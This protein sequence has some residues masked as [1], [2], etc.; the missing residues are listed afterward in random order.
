[1]AYQ[2][3]G[4]TPEVT[5]CLRKA[6]DRVISL[7]EERNMYRAMVKSLKKDENEIKS[8]VIREVAEKLDYQ[9][10]VEQLGFYQWLI[11][12]AEKYND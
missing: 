4:Y 2:P 10:D 7:R 9:N 5:E 8:N 1:M 12:E 6:H 3:I 11:S